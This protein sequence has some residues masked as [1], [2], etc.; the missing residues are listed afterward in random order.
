MW[1]SILYEFIKIIIVK[2][3]KLLYI[4]KIILHLDNLFKKTKFQKIISTKE[5]NLKAHTLVD[6]S[7]NFKYL[8]IVPGNASKP[9]FIPLYIFIVSILL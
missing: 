9:N 3:I 5:I 7:A 6:H 8:H 1:L 2:I 4:I